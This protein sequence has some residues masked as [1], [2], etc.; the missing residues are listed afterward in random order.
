MHG[1][2]LPQIIELHGGC[3]V[4]GFFPFKHASAA[5]SVI[6][7]A[8]I[9]FR[10][11]ILGGEKVQVVRLLDA[12]PEK[13]TEI[14]QFRIRGFAVI[15]ESCPGRCAPRF[16]CVIELY[17]LVTSAF[18]PVVVLDRGAGYTKPGGVYV[19]ALE[20]VVVIMIII[21]CVRDERLY[22]AE[23]LFCRPCDYPL[24]LHGVRKGISFKYSRSV[25]GDAVTYLLIVL[26]DLTKRIG[27][28]SH[29][30]RL[31]LGVIF[32]A[33]FLVKPGVP[34]LECRFGFGR[35]IGYVY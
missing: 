24:I 32:F 34:F 19:I 20:R 9:E 10:S 3:L 22:F 12:F 33:C 6:Q 27:T 11:Y 4:G 18:E 15:M 5:E 14:A 17:A 23:V 13:G 2:F 16:K 8:E 35:G 26:L 25:F 28:R 7:K 31:L 21:A 30:L 29:E 1:I